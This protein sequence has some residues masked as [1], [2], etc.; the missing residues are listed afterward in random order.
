MLGTSDLSYAWNFRTIAECCG[1]YD[2]LWIFSM[3]Y[4]FRTEAAAYKIDENKMRTKY[5]GFTVHTS[6]LNLFLF[7][8]ALSPTLFSPFRIPSA[9]ISF[10]FPFLISALMM[11]I[12][13][14]VIK[15]IISGELP[16]STACRTYLSHPGNCFGKITRRKETHG[17]FPPS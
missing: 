10:C 6:S 17:F 9:W 1:F 3:H 16:I 5:S 4:I 12:E 13:D 2:L 8:V 14:V 15:T 11:R 7:W